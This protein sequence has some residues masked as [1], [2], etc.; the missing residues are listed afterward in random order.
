MTEQKTRFE[1][2]PVEIAEDA[3]RL[4]PSQSKIIANE[5]T[6]F[7]NLLPRRVGVRRPLRRHLSHRILRWTR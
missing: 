6:A 4:Q 5:S 2:V 1:Q 7:T 3:L